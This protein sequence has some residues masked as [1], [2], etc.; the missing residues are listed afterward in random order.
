MRKALLYIFIISLSLSGLTQ[1]FKGEY[2]YLNFVKT[3]TKQLIKDN[4]RNAEIVSDQLI[5]SGIKDKEI[6]ALFFMELGDNYALIDKAEF[7]LFSYLR[8]RFLFPNDSIGLYVEK[9]IRVNAIRLNIDKQM[10]DYLIQKSAPHNLV[11]NQETN[12]NNLIYWSSKIET[13]DLTYILLHQI[14][15][16]NSCGMSQFDYLLKWED[17]SRIGIPLK[18]KTDYLEHDFKSLNLSQKE[19]YYK[20]QTRYFLKHKA[21]D[22][23]ENSLSTLNSL[24]PNKT[25]GFGYLKLRTK[26]H[27]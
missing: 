7:A 24:N 11:K 4:L 1:N 17:L 3:Q 6:T 27:F 13:K 22:R 2:R 26:W 25:S 16:M 9:Q 5:Y 10:A 18:Y 12:L 20:Y 23:A 21:R 8:Q 15:L 14:D 19:L